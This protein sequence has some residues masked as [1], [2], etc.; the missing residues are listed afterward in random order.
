MWGGGAAHAEMTV[1][2]PIMYSCAFIERIFFLFFRSAVVSLKWLKAV[3]LCWCAASVY[4]TFFH[5]RGKKRSY[6]AFS[7]QFNS[8][9]G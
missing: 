2:V 1:H 9:P 5:V 4:L 7:P 8:C 3:V 6:S